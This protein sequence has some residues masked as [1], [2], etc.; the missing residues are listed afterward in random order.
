MAGLRI[1]LKPTSS[2]NVVFG[3]RWPLRPLGRKREGGGRSCI[4]SRPSRGAPAAQ[5]EPL[6]PPATPPQRARQRG[7]NRGGT[8]L[9]PR[10]ALGGELFCPDAP[11]AGSCPPRPAG[12]AQ[13]AAPPRCA[14]AQ[15]PP[16]E[17]GH[18]RPQTLF[19]LRSLQARALL[20]GRC[21][22]RQHPRRASPR[23]RDTG[24]D[25]LPRPAAALQRW[26]PLSPLHTHP[27]EV[28]FQ[29]GAP[30]L[31]PCP[32]APLGVGRTVTARGGAYAPLRRGSTPASLILPFSGLVAPG[33]LLL[34]GAGLGGLQ[35]PGSRAGGG[36][37]A[38]G[39]RT[40]DCSSWRARPVVIQVGMWRKLLCCKPPF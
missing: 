16:A 33:R 30:S 25:R 9:K 14:R 15:Q 17:G 22:R 23:R 39:G 24:P 29:R 40:G 34:A 20:P 8:G 28:G 18:P 11:G 3:H 26:R 6:P 10:P 37:R 13:E 36:L 2:K 7:Q 31:P 5:E 38:G 4:G 1:S 32:E 19:C 21:A 27:L 35:G 12:E